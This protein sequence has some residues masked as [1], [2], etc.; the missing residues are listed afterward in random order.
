[1]NERLVKMEQEILILSDLTGKLADGLC[2]LTDFIE[3]KLGAPTKKALDTNRGR[4]AEVTIKIATEGFTKEQMSAMF[5][6]QELLCELGINFDTGMNMKTGVRDWEWD[7]SL[8]G[9]IKVVFKCW[10]D[11]NPTN[12]YA[13]R[14]PNNE[15]GAQSTAT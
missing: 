8:R 15:T 4:E 13:I 5:K 11:E 3:T 9:P 6:A 10:V 14:E 2:K 7:W 1:M 12:R